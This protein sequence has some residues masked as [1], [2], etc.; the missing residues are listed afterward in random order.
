V[1]GHGPNGLAAQGYPASAGEQDGCSLSRPCLCQVARLAG[2]RCPK[3][4]KGSRKKATRPSKSGRMRNLEKEKGCR[5]AGTGKGQ[6]RYNWAITR[7]G[8]L[9]SAYDH[10]DRAATA[11]PTAPILLA[12]PS[13]ATLRAAPC[14][15][16]LCRFW[17]LFATSAF[18]LL[19]SLRLE[20]EPWNISRSRPQLGF[21]VKWNVQNR[22]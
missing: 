2:D 5:A 13:W 9:P 20:T 19:P 4:T 18:R 22:E 8:S 21:W 7:R 11:G 10:S 1:Q 17:S 15:D 3:H 16:N 14:A 12:R 6:V